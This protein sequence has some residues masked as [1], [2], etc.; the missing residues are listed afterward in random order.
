MTNP[1]TKKARNRKSE[2]NAP[3]KVYIT[4]VALK[5][6]KLI[7]DHVRCPL[8]LSKTPDSEIVAE[9]R[10][11]FMA[12]YNM[13]PQWMAPITC[14]RTSQGVE[15]TKTPRAKALDINSADVELIPGR[16]ATAIYKDWEVTVRFIQGRDD[17]VYISRCKNIKD[18]GKIASRDYTPVAMSALTNLVEQ[19]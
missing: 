15:K 12:Q 14:N 8:A 1:E 3:R 19:S 18:P 16:K 4:C 5:D 7:T 9:A 6:G 17:A 2:T 11:L 10:G 13:E